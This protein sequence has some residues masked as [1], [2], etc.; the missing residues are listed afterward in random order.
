MTVFRMRP[1][2]EEPGYHC[3]SP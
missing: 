3:W 2:I 1:T